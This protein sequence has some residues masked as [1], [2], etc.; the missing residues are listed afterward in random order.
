MLNIPQNKLIAVI[1]EMNAA[2]LIIDA[3]KLSNGVPD[4][5][6]RCPTQDK[7]RGLNG[8]YIIKYDSA[9]DFVTIVYGN[10]EQGDDHKLKYHINLKAPDQPIRTSAERQRLQAQINAKIATDRAKQVQERNRKAAY[11][12]A[13]FERLPECKSHPYTDRKSIDEIY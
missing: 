5:R 13:E 4:K 10:F 1:Y 12:R 6:Y 7:P 11:Y 3:A 2:G 9:L 8:W